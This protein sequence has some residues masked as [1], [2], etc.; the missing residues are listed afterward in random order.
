MNFRTEFE[1]D[2]TVYG[3]DIEAPERRTSASRWTSAYNSHPPNRRPH[4]WDEDP[5]N[6][7]PWLILI[8]LDSW[9]VMTGSRLEI[10]IA[11]LAVLVGPVIGW[12]ISRRRR[13]RAAAAGGPYRSASP[14][15][16][17]TV[18][19]DRADW[20]RVLAI[21]GVTSAVAL[22]FALGAAL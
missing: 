11:W 21:F 6:K 13:S 19:G 18:A 4:A 9:L 7:Y 5:W 10:V 1:A 14:T 12:V 16:T 3:R 8:H 2:G 22:S 17:E 15:E 20:A